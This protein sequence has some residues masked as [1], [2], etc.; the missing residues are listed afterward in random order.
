[1]ALAV[2]FRIIVLTNRL[3]RITPWNPTANAARNFKLFRYPAIR[4]VWMESESDREL[5]TDV[6]PLGNIL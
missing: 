4:A 6:D 3:I 5:I 2:L 1:M